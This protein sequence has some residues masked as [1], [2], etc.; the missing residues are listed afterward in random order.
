V[1]IAAIPYVFGDETIVKVLSAAF[2]AVGVYFLLYIVELGYRLLI[3]APK[4]I[5]G[6]EHKEL[7]HRANLIRELEDARKPRLKI[8]FE[9]RFPYEDKR[10]TYKLFRVGIDVCRSLT[11]DDPTVEIADIEPRPLHLFPPFP[12]GHMH[13]KGEK[14]AALHPGREPQ[15]YDVVQQL[16]DGT[17]Q[18]VHGISSA[19]HNLPPGDYKVVIV[20]SGRD[21]RAEPKRFKISVP[22]PVPGQLSLGFWP[23]EGSHSVAPQDPTHDP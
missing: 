13:G 12:L 3:L 22:D 2:T 1:L 14:L 11:V 10:E 4:E 20:A 6:K 15:S 19:G 7:E 5:F 23:I 17:V 21:S 18:L 9:R 8:V 16:A